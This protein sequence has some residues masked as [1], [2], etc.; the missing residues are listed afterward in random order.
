LPLQANLR[1]YTKAAFQFTQPEV[2]SLPE[3]GCLSIL[4]WSENAS[5][6][7]FRIVEKIRVAKKGYDRAN[8]P[9]MLIP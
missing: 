9:W 8:A 4:R 2:A 1:I 5:P 3:R 6:D 7:P